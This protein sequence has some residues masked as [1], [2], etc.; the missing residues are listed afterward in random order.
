MELTTGNTGAIMGNVRG[1]DVIERINQKKG[2]IFIAQVGSLL[3]SRTSSTISR[4]L[5]SMLKSLAG[6]VYA[7]GKTLDPPLSLHADEAQNIIYHGFEDLVSKAGSANFMFHGYSQSI[8][9]IYDALGGDMN[10]GKS[11][12]SNI[13][14]KIFMRA[15]DVETA[16][17]ISKHFGPVKR[18]SP[19]FSV[20][21][22]ITMREMEDV[23]LTEEQVMALNP[24]EFYM[25][26]YTGK[27]K[28]R[29][30]P[31]SEAVL[32]VIYPQAE[33]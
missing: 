13:N 33:V 8:S 23:L 24:Q 29:T 6:R 32:N 9:Q 21:G 3:T 20:S 16:Q 22:N 7:S 19:I 25:R 17:Y 12:L 1:N 5:I 26:T 11:I 15:P 27:Y 4:V 14:T 30:S 28:G 10:K 18:L 31:V 2:V